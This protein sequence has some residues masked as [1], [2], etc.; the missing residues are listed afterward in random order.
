MLATLHNLIT[1]NNSK[2]RTIC[3]CYQ[4][5]YQCAN[6]SINCIMVP[7]VHK[8]MLVEN[9]GFNL[10][11]FGTAKNFDTSGSIF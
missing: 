8:K 2:E 9:S 10:E 3:A 6:V 1:N 5:C 11:Y 4:T 7:H